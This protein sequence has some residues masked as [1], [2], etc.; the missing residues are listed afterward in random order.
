MGSFRKSPSHCLRRP[1]PVHEEAIDAFRGNPGATSGLE[2]LGE[3]WA[4]Y[5]DTYRPKREA[6]KDEIRRVMD[7]TKLVSAGESPVNDKLNVSELAAYS[8]VASLILNLD[9]TV[10]KE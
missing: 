3:D 6:T 9:E 2:Y 1:R 5:K 10:T 7:F 4:R 8:T